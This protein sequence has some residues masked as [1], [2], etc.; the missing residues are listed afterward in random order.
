MEWNKTKTIFILAFLVLDIFLG[1]QYFEKR[2]TDHFAI[3]EK[4][5]TLEE[6]KADGIKYGNLSDEAKIGY[7]ITAEKKQYTKKDVDGLADQKTKSTFPKTEKDDPVTLLEMTFNKPVALPKKDMKTAATNL[8]SQRLLDGKNYKLWSIDE[9]SGEIVFFQTY[10]G[11]YIFQEGLDDT[12][13]IGKITLDVNDQNEV[14]SYRQSMVTSI[15]EV[16]KETLVP[17]LETV[18]DLYTQNMLSQNTTVKKVELGYYTQYPGASTQ[19]MVPVWRVEIEGVAT[20]S[21]KKTEEEYLINAIDGS[22]LDHIEK[23]DKSSL[24]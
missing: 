6:M 11:K 18:K 12:E 17:A 5:D 3:I 7:R 24:E 13:T 21:K 2:S 9:E 14:V 23:E 1:F 10:K 15:N 22:T 8:V 20:G 19:V 4:T 16:R